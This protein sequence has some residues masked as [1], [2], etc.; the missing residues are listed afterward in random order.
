M[1]CDLGSF[2]SGFSISDDRANKSY[3]WKYNKIIVLFECKNPFFFL[4]SMYI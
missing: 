2:T 3:V 1:G 4:V